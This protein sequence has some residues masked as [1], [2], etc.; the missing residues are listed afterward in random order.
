[1]KKLFILTA[2]ALSILTICSCKNGNR[3]VA[4][5]GVD[6]NWQLIDDGSQK[7]PE[8]RL[9]G[10]PEGTTRFFV[11]LVDLNNK[12]FDHGGG[13]V[14]NDGTGVIGRGATKG[15][16]NGP[17]P[18]FPNMIHNYEITVEAFDKKGTVIG[19]GRKAKKF[20]PQKP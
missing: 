10:V 12:G 15:N 14:D 19:I 8:I 16:Y 4:E 11:G 6:F 17:N 18:P 2:I 20:P 3:N 1:M 7:N 5:I 9:S 13:F